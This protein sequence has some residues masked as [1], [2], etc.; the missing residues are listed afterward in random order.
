LVL[1]IHKVGKLLSPPQRGR[2]KECPAPL[3]PP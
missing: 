3:E 1:L 2:Q